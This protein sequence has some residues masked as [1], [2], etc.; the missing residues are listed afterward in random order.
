[1][2]H[3]EVFRECF[4][5]L[6]LTEEHYDKLSE[7]KLCRAFELPEGFALVKENELRMLCVLPQKRGNGAGTRL[8]RFAE[9]YIRSRGYE[10]MEIGGAGSGLLIGAPEDTCGFF[11]KMGC[12]LDDRVAEMSIGKL[13]LPDKPLSGADFF[14]I[15]K[16]FPPI[17]GRKYFRFPQFNYCAFCACF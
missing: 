8:F 17:F 12:T 7:E 14:A 1:M 15:F 6:K 16:L 10:R 11:E 4:P 3:Y 5:E 2:T 9:D 13:N